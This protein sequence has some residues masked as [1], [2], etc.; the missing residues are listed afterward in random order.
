M[1]Q[2]K[3]MFITQGEIRFNIISIDD[4][5]NSIKI[6]IVKNK[7]LKIAFSNPEFVI[8]CNKYPFLKTY[9]N[10]CDFN[11]I[12]G[13]GIVL[14]DFFRSFKIRQRIT[15]TDFVKHLSLFSQ[16]HNFSIYFL[17]GEEGVAENAIYNLK[18]SYP[19]L[20]FTGCH[21]GYLDTVNTNNVID[22]I[23]R[24]K[25][26]ILMVC[27]GNP[28]Q[29]EWINENVDKLNVNLIFGNGGAM[30]FFS[31]KFKRAPLLL[32]IIGLEWIFR[33]AQDF[34]KPRIKRVFNSL[35]YPIRIS[36]NRL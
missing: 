25:T 15:G 21:H 10:S 36:F 13:F 35:S 31:N 20:I 7:K 16:K 3:N 1:Y 18:I 22:E 14:V 5:L 30:D 32:R 19:N 33:L 24:N 12:D 9:L 29:E 26:N 4:L 27:M 2:S 28:V 34:N 23:N 6:A 8:N 11:L 17:G